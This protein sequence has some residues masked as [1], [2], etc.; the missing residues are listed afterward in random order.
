VSGVLT[1]LPRMSE[2]QDSILSRISEYQNSDIGI[3]KNSDI[4]DT[5]RDG[6]LKEYQNYILVRISEF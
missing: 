6:A 1:I 3:L 4:L 2:Y 5:R